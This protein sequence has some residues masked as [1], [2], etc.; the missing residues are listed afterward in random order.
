MLAGGK[1]IIFVD[2]FAETE[3]MQ[4]QMMR[5]SIEGSSLAKLFDTWGLKYDPAKVV[6][7]R[8]S[9]RKVLPEAGNRL[10][11]YLPG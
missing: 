11:E 4:G 1:A 10:I 3:A 7:D 2:P 6:V 5:P 9:A 8:L